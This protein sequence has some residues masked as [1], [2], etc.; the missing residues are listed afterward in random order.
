[1]RAETV[2]SWLVDETSDG[3]RADKAVHEALQE[4]EDEALALSRSR[5]QKLID[6]GHATLDGQPMKASTKLREG[7]RIELRVP[8]PVSLEVVAEDRPLEILYQD[9]HLLVVNKAPG[10]TVHP[11]ETQATGTLVHA[12]LF[13][14][15]DLSGIGGVQRPGIVHRLDKDTSGALVVAK[16]DEA[17]RKLVETFSKH[18]IERRYWA[19]CYGVPKE[20]REQRIESLLGRSPSDRK[21]MA[22]DIKEGRR[23]VT[24]W[25]RLET[26][27]NFAS[28]IEARLET[29]RT[30]QVRV[31]L[32]SAGHS[33]LG[34]P[35]YGAV[36][37]KQ[38]KWQMLPMPVR[39]AVRAL[40]GQALHARVL[41]FTHP[42]T[43]EKLRFEAEPPPAFAR[44]LETLR[45]TPSRG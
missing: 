37:D 16:S 30:H 36:A 25:R 45:S 27:G 38:H 23:S 28:L 17:H 32:T 29:G 31:H 24:H 18:D 10:V 1:M 14:I 6:D 22:I 12:L 19:L 9:Q 5:V 26:Y 2:W 15:K 40:P 11:S 42:V 20:E 21:K 13:H 35:V 3:Q 33:L 43:G 4:E 34:D 44:V 41:G 8:P 7:M 39:D